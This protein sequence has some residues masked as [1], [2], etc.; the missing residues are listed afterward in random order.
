MAE[1]GFLSFAAQ[2]IKQGYSFIFGKKMACVAL[3]NPAGI[4]RIMIFLWWHTWGI[5]GGYRNWGDWLYYLIGLYDKAPQ[6]SPL[7]NGMS[8]SNIGL[9]L[10]A[11]A[12][13]LF[14]KQFKINPAPKWEYL[15]G[16]VGGAL[17]G[18]GAALSAGCNVGAFYSALG[19][20][21]LSGFLMMIGLFTGAYIGLKY[22]LWEMEHIEVGGTGATGAKDANFDKIKPFFWISGDSSSDNCIF[23]SIQNLTRP[24]WEG[25][26]SLDF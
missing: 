3:W 13:A 7:E 15:K 19:M 4:S 9:V 18:I 2:E 11:L 22:L 5:A 10:G 25:F 14:S 17:M 6:K 20:L 26:F 1:N 12:S 16:I 24:R 21:D 23:L 8:V